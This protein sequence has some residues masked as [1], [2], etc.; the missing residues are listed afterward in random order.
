MKK[1]KPITLPVEV[2]ARHIHLSQKDADKLFGKKYKLRRFKNL[3]QTGE[4]AAAEKVK[5]FSPHS[6]TMD[7][8]VLGPMRKETQVEL[9]LTDAI[10]L[11][12]V[13]PIVLSGDLK[14][15][16]PILEVRG[17]KGKI[18][19]KAIVAKRHL[20]CNLVVAKKLG[21]KNG[22]KVKI[23]IVG[24][25]GLIFDNVIA[26][27]APDY[28]LSCHLDTDEANACGLGKICGV[29]KLIL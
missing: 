27:V 26:R 11:G 20:H 19:A 29:G 8:R 16:K 28:N 25:R 14:K 12:I 6:T 10:K 4:F 2:S 23:E 22:Q 21:I 17:P 5:I 7:L 15:V 13:A 9:S 18:M 24:E 3:S 1:Q